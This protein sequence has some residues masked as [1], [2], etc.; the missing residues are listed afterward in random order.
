MIAVMVVDENPL[1]KEAL[2][3]FIASAKD[4]ALV[5]STGDSRQ[6]E[7]VVPKPTPDVVLVDLQQPVDPGLAA[8]RAITERFPNARVLVVTATHHENFV[9]AALDA[10]VNGYVGKDAT[11][12]QVVDAVRRVQAGELVF[13][14]PVLRDLVAAVRNRPLHPDKNL[15]SHEKLT[16]READVVELLVRG[17][18][19]AEIART[20]CLAEA[21]VKGHLGRVTEKWGVRDRL[22]V[23]LKATST[24]VVRAPVKRG[25]GECA[26]A[27]TCQAAPTINSDRA[28]R[29]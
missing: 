4:L 25:A 9:L 15:K 6:A 13:S 8:V 27:H 22:Q 26:S 28:L 1:M 19:N 3:L 2:E 12:A 21:T 17:K 20:L 14:Q 11:S 18:S 7:Q 23:V 24:G 10:G 16:P 5:G 29:K